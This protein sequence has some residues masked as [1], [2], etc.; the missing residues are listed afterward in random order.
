MGC[1]PDSV[2]AQL[3]GGYITRDAITAWQHQSRLMMTVPGLRVHDA[4]VLAGA[5]ITT[6]E[7]L[8]AAPAA[9]LFELAMEFLTSPDGGRV[10]REEGE[11][12]EA[13]VKGWIGLAR[14]A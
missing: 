7:E 13:D 8:A 4:Q 12:D 14:S 1:D 6:R 9:D 5:G 3:G 10:A 11:L 2:V